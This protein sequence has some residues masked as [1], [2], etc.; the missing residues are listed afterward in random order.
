[1]I[2][3]FAL[4]KRRVFSEDLKPRVTFPDFMTRARRELSVS[5]VFLVL[6]GGILLGFGRMLEEWYG[7]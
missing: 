3:S 2:T 4:P 5:A 7:W 6:R 1:M